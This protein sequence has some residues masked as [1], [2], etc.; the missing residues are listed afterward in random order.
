MHRGLGVLSHERLEDS[1][2]VATGDQPMM[3]S[4]NSSATCRICGR[5]LFNPRSVARG[6]GPVCWSKL[7][8]HDQKEQAVISGMNEY[9][10]RTL[11][12]AE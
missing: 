2:G 6:I 5:S 10:N 3:G 1:T 4:V 8:L 12:E 9:R 7:S 11:S